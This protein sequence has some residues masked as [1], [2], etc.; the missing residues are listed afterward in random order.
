MSTLTAPP[1]EQPL[2]RDWRNGCAVDEVLLVREVEERRK[3]DGSPYLRMTLG[4]RSGSVPAVLWSPESVGA[5]ASEAGVALHVTGS[6]AEHPRYGR[7]VTVSDVHEP[8]ED[9]IDWD[10]LLDGPVRAVEELEQELERLIGSVREPHLSQLMEKLLGDGSLMRQA[11]VEVPAAKYNHHAYRNGLLDHSVG[12][13]QLVDAAASIF[14]S[15]N[16]DLAVCGALLHDIGKLEA[17]AGDQTGV[18]LTDAGKLEGE[19]P[20]G[21][22]RVR[23]EIETVP[24]F[25]PRLAQALFHIIL[26][27]HGRLEHGSPVVPSTREAL[28]VHA[29]DNLSGQLGAFDRLEKETAAGEQWSRFDRVLEG[30]AFFGLPEV[31]PRGLAH[32]PAACVR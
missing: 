23:R 17:Y 7:Q 9:E 2:L 15:L 18:D 6:F 13:A 22:Y 32:G 20:L 27:H 3:R 24:D 4:D 25:P 16:R 10:R 29:V 14:P 12:I 28:L 30:A 21:Y 8:V 5:V 31:S 11:F 1:S 19:I 26:S